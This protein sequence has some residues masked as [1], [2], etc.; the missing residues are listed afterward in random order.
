MRKFG[1]WRRF[2]LQWLLVTDHFLNQHSLWSNPPSTNPNPPLP[3]SHPFS[4]KLA[5]PSPSGNSSSTLFFHFNVTLI[6]TLLFSS[7]QVLP[8]A[9]LR[10]VT[11][12]LALGG[13]IC[14]SHFLPRNRFNKFE[15]FVSG[16]A[17]QC[18]PWCLIH[19]HRYYFLSPF[20]SV[21]ILQ[22]FIIHSHVFL[23][24]IFSL[25]W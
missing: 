25:F 1:G 20:L 10:T 9:R 11:P 5:L 15:I 17:L 18:Q 23:H 21:S 22:L 16:Y 24:F 7:V 12:S 2:V 6:L 14:A 19:F 13:F 4:S 3:P 8:G